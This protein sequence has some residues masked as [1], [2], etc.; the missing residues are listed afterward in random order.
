MQDDRLRGSIATGVVLY[1]IAPHGSAAAKSEHAFY[2]VPQLDGDG[3]A[4]I[5]GGRF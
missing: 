2:L 3:G 5:V 4:V 1:L